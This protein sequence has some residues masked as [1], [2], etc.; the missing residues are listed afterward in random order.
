MNP[1]VVLIIQARMGS[2]RLPGKSMMDLAGAP[3]MIGTPFCMLPVTALNGNSIGNGMVGEGF[4]RLISQ[5]SANTGVDI[6]G[7]I[8]KW[9]MERAGTNIGNTPTPYRFKP[10]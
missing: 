2:S 10:K 8:K 4:N 5:W 7:Q 1:K 9:D 6:V 3:F